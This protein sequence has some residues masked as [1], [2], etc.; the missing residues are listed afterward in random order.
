MRA[1]DL[2]ANRSLAEIQ[3]P[4]S[5]GQPKLTLRH[6]HKL[7]LI[8]RRQAKERDEKLAMLPVM[9]GDADHQ[10]RMRELELE[11]AELEQHKREADDAIDRRELEIEQAIADAELDNKQREKISAMAI[12]TVN[13]QRKD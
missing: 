9:Y 13:R 2:Y 10:H 12:N 6:L 5:N 4:T 11:Q 1:S 3:N 8:R 7:K